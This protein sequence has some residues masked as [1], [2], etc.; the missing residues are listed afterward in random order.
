MKKFEI[1]I[2]DMRSELRS[3]VFE[4]EGWDEAVAIAEADDT[5]TAKDGWEDYD[6]NT[7]CEIREDLSRELD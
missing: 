2:E 3:K 5:W 7:N 4:A 6:T 1:V